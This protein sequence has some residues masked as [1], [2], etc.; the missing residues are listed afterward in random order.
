MDIENVL[1]GLGGSVLGFAG[2]LA[3]PWVKYIINRKTILDLSRRELIENWRTA[4]SSNGDDGGE[5]RDSHEYA[6]LR[7]H[8]DEEI[9]K[10][11]EHS[12]TVIFGA[13]PNPRKRL[14]L[15]EVARIEKSWNLI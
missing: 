10:R 14:M 3:A 12:R 5:F 4:I 1:I 7:L 15:A 11:I 9:I 6:S 8:M 2:G 13:G